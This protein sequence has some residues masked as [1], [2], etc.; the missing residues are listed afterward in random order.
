[1]ALILQNGYSIKDYNQKDYENCYGV[2]DQLNINKSSFECYFV[3]DIFTS[4]EA[5]DK[6]LYPVLSLPYC[7]PKNEFDKFF[8]LKV[9]Q[10]KGNQYCCA[11]DYLRQLKEFERWNNDI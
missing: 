7:V 6:K 8:S 10:E 2:I 3:F 11:Y 5:R 4:K 9:I 1:M